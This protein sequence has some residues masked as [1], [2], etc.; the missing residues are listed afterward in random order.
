MK[1]LYEILVPT[2]F[3]MPK[4]KKIPKKHHKKWDQ[5]IQGISGGLTILAPSKG[6]WTFDSKEFHEKILPVRILCEEA[7]IE[8]IIEF[9][10]SHYRQH[11]VMYYVISDQAH[12]K[13]A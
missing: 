5:V 3:G 6:R 7:D 12:I 13:Y 2:K 11:A 8:K 1:K 10:I 9:T 4:V